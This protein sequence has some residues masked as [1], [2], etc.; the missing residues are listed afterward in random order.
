M[1]IF[2]AELGDKTQIA[3]LAISGTSK[4]P[5]AVFIGSSSALV[6]ASFLGVALGGSISNVIPTYI[7]QITA[8]IG[9]FIIGLSLLIST[10]ETT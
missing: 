10:K 9:F 3:T 4:R 1:T 5:L 6:L 8:S 7:L 2:L